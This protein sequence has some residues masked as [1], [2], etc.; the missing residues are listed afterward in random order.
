MNDDATKRIC[1]LGWGTLIGAGLFGLLVWPTPYEFHRLNSIRYTTPATKSNY[2]TLDWVE[3][4]KP[5]TPGS[6]KRPEKA[7]P[8]P[9]EV[10]FRVNRITGNAEKVAE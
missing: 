1:R 4:D 10:L 2:T 6:Q 7:T 8:R 9:R 5:E 3:D